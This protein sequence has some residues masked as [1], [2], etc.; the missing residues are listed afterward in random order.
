MRSK[1]TI[2][3]YYIKDLQYKIGVTRLLLQNARLGLGLMLVHLIE[4]KDWYLHLI[5]KVWITGLG[6]QD[7]CYRM[8]DK[9]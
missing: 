8:L 3:I 4:V 9:V 1:I 5:E 7:Y 2:F 6:L